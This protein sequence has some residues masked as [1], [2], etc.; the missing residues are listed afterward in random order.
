M[1]VEA[2]VPPVFHIPSTPLFVHLF[3]DWDSQ[4][5]MGWRAEREGLALLHHGRQPR[6]GRRISFLD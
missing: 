4:Q 5:M 3:R 6:A 2:T 1:S